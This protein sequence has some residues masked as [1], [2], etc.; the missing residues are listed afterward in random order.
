M[1]IL[2]IGPESVFTTGVRCALVAEGHQVAFIDERGLRR[3]PFLWRLVRRIRPLRR[4]SN[5]L[6][7]WHIIRRARQFCPSM[8]CIIKGTRVTTST[9]RALKA[10]GVTLVNWFP[11]SSRNELYRVWLDR[12]VGWYDYFF[13]FDSEFLERQKDFPN[14]RL[15]YMPFGVDPDAFSIDGVSADDHKKYDADVC[16]IGAWY[17]EREQILARL[18]DFDLKVFGWKGWEK[19]SVAHRYGGPLNAHESAIACRCANIVL[20]MN[21]QPPVHGVN[22]KTFEICASGGFQLTDFRSDLPDLFIAD[23]EL[24]VFR[25][26]EEL[27]AIIRKYL[28]DPQ[29]RERIARAGHARVMRDHTLRKR[30]RTMITAIA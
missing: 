29:A 23:R 12:H 3:W 14:T 30:V 18:E 11:E 8:A 10:M 4:I 15:A 1:K 16:F 9:L 21:I 17:P 7:G 6:L 13:I 2:L 5:Q 24:V 26:P 19:T 25:S 28:D 20:N 22:A 27:V